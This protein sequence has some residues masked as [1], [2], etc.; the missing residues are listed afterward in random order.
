MSLFSPRANKGGAPMLDPDTLTGLLGQLDGIARGYAD[1]GRATPLI[2]PPGLR[3]GVRRLIEPVLPHIPVV[4]LA[5]LPPQVNL[6]SIA[7][8]ELDNA[9]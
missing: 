4:S 5:E 3:I 2:T 7:T 9:A 1:D 6:R 8:W